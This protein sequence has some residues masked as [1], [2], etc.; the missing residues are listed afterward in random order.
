M[1]KLMVGKR[2]VINRNVG[3]QELSVLLYPD[4]T[5]LVSVTSQEI[6]DVFQHKETTI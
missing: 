6:S 2:N 1:N 5:D 3:K 4:D